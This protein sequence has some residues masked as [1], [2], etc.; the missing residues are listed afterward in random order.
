M[1][2]GTEFVLTVVGAVLAYLIVL[3]ILIWWVW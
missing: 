1:R 3:G 2:E